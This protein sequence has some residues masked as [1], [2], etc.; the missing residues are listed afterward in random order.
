MAKRDEILDAVISSDEGRKLDANGIFERIKNDDDIVVDKN[1]GKTPIVQQQDSTESPKKEIEKCETFK[2][3]FDLVDNGEVDLNEDENKKAFLEKVDE[4]VEDKEYI[5]S[6]GCKILGLEIEDTDSLLDV[7]DGIKLVR[8]FGRHNNIKIVVEDASCL[9]LLFGG[10]ECCRN[11][12]KDDFIEYRNRS[13]VGKIPVESEGTNFNIKIGGRK[14]GCEIDDC[15]KLARVLY[16][17]GSVSGRDNFFEKKISVDYDNAKKGQY[18]IFGQTVDFLNKVD[19]SVE[20]EVIKLC[21]ECGMFDSVLKGV[22][23]SSDA[24]DTPLKKNEA[25]AFIMGIEIK[26]L[27]IGKR[28]GKEEKI[29]E[30]AVD[31]FKTLLGREDVKWDES[32]GTVIVDC[33]NNNKIQLS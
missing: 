27:G 15:F 3:L 7:L 1:D 30:V 8:S 19:Y 2:E 17:L 33:P 31:V 12:Y 5:L 32:D 25:G 28:L 4:I 21:R 29:E 16:S 14:L 20:Y 10:D 22:I 11:D 23:V 9:E 18:S 13:S 6:R 24:T 26:N